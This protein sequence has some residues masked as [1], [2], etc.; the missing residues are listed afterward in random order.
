VA[1]SHTIL[2]PEWK[3]VIDMSTTSPAV[4][5]DSRQTTRDVGGVAN[6][7]VAEF[8]FE[9]DWK[10]ADGADKRGRVADRARR[11]R[12]AR[13]PVGRGGRPHLAA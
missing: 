6:T 8:D 1:A 3:I 10:R 13:T 7:A 9:R 5:A 11:Y 12:R 2:I 4:A